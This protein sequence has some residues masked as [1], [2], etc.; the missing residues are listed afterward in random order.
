VIHLSDTGG[1][2]V[3]LLLWLGVLFFLWARE[4]W[5]LRRR[6][7]RLSRTRLFH[8]RKCHLSF[9]NREDDGSMTRC[10]RCNAVCLRRH[11]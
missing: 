9:L 11:H 8:C 6:D 10:P 3:Y 7:W 5:R 1:L 4:F 2:T